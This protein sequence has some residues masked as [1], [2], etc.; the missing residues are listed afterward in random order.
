MAYG[1]VVH[2]GSGPTFTAGFVAAKV[3][4]RAFLN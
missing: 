4:M 2:P 3:M 1:F